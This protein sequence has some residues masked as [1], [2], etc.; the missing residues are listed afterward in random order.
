MNKRGQYLLIFPPRVLN[1]VCKSVR[2]LG[3]YGYTIKPKHFIPY[4]DAVECEILC[5]QSINI[6]VWEKVT[7]KKKN[8]NCIYDIRMRTKCS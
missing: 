1:L 3:I 6:Y 7:Q 8:N 2:Q 5:R 4:R